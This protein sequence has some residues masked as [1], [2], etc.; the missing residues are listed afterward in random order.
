[1][2]VIS[3]VACFAT[4]GRFPSSLRE[5][6]PPRHPRPSRALLRHRPSM[7][8]REGREGVAGE[9][10]LGRRGGGRPRSRARGGASGVENRSVGRHHLR[11]RFFFYCSRERTAC[12][13]RG[14]IAISLVACQ[15][16]V[17]AIVGNSPS[18]LVLGQPTLP[19]NAINQRIVVTTNQ[20]P[21]PPIGHSR[22][23]LRIVYPR[24]SRTVP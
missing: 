19:F 14:T 20:I 5:A 8:S 6:N 11:H 23:V 2:I 22:P 12:Q 13:A 21:S 1:M 9:R 4:V 7:V 17:Q 10:A 3:L 15:A 24:G 16:I 18:S